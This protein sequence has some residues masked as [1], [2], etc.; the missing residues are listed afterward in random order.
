M[1]IIIFFKDFI[2]K[3]LNLSLNPQ[4]LYFIPFIILVSGISQIYEQ[5]S[6]R[7]EQFS[8]TARTNFLNS[9][10][11]NGGK[12]IVGLRFASESILI[13]FTSLREAIKAI[14]T[15][16]LFNKKNKYDY[17]ENYNE[18][19][20]SLLEIANKYADFPLYRAPELI[21]MH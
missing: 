8:I 9:L 18:E 3:T 19:S 21:L 11:I 16:Y 12:V 15:G 10:I 13:I 5:L 17:K 2:I 1:L 6:I 7:K 20:I 14:M 4:Y